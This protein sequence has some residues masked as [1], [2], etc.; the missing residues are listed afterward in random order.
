MAL[1]KEQKK[2]ITAQVEEF[3]TNVLGPI[4]DEDVQEAI[5]LLVKQVESETALIVVF[6]P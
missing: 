2:E 6:Q 4:E 5:D 3:V 1:S